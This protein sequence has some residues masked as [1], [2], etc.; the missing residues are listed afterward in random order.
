MQHWGIEFL[1]DGCYGKQLNPK[2]NEYTEK[3]YSYIPTSFV[4]EIADQKY[5]RDITRTDKDIISNL[6]VSISRVGFLEPGWIVY[7]ESSVRLKDGNHR[8][9]AALHLG[10]E[11]YPATFSK[12]ENISGGH[13]K[14]S[15]LFIKILENQWLHPS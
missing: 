3:K 4:N 8:L 9:I 15:D 5:L 11:K 12:V 1:D 6:I 2:I 14:I 10:L 13:K 7:D